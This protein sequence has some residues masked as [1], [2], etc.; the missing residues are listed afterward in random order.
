MTDKRSVLITGANGGIGRAAV[1]EFSRLGWDVIG[2]D[3]D[4]LGFESGQ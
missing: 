1:L 4:P 3:R 2:V